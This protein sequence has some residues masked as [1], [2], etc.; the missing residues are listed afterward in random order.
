MP[1]SVI[2]GTISPAKG[3]SGQIGGRWR[4]AQMAKSPRTCRPWASESLSLA[5]R[6]QQVAAQ[7][8]QQNFRVYRLVKPAVDPG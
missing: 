6:R 7:V 3:H 2:R 5:L 1:R 8:M 4:L